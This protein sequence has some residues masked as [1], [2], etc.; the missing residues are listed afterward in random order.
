MGTTQFPQATAALERTIRYVKDFP[1]LGVIF[2]DLTPALADA[3]A[4]REII[5]ALAQ[6]ARDC[7]AELIGGLDARGFLLGS[8]VAYELGLG[9]VAIRKKGKLPPPVIREE[10]SLE[11]GTA[12]LE[13]PA[14]GMDLAG[15]K[16]VLIDDV[17]A[18]GGTLVAAG[19]LL[20]RSGAEVV[21]HAVVLE[22]P[23]LGGREKLGTSPLV[24]VHP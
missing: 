14:E 2:Q 20:R 17:L 22:V 4:F 11:Y 7:G 9:V 13:I 8:A 21:G 23:G 24:V 1:E 5:K 3:E 15:R 12:C 18:T 16:I 6:A 19:S 10:Y